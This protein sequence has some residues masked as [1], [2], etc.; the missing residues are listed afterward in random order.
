MTPEEALRNVKNPEQVYLMLEAMMIQRA[1][2]E[3]TANNDGLQDW[4]VDQ[5]LS[6][7]LLIQF[8]NQPKSIAE[9]LSRKNEFSEDIQRGLEVTFK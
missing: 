8:H 6:A 5:T 2:A 4:F 3:E 1:I 9:C 7:G